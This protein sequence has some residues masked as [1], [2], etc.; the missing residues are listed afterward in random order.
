MACLEMRKDSRWWYGRWATGGKLYVKNLDILIQGQRPESIGKESDRRFE[1]SRYRAQAKLDE[2]VNK[3]NT[4]RHTSEL[5]QTLHEIKT[6]NRIGSI[7]IQALYPAWLSISRHKAASKAHKS[8]AAA[9]FKRFT[10]YLRDHHAAVKE[11]AQVTHEMGVGFMKAETDRKT[12][13]RTSN[14]SLSLLRGS[15]R[16]LRRT[17]GIAD[18]PFDSIETEEENTIHRKPFAPDELT[19]VFDAARADEFC[20]P[21]IITGACTAMRRGDVCLLRWRDVDLAKRFISVKTSKTGAE[22]HIPIFPML[23]EELESRPRTNEYCFPEQAAMYK[24]NPSGI[25]TRL[26]RVFA[27]A[28]FADEGAMRRKQLPLLAEIQQQWTER[29]AQQAR[30]FTTKVQRM[31]PR[32]LALYTGGATINDCMGQLGLSKGAVSTYLKRIENILGYS[33]VRTVREPI[34]LRDAE[35]GER[36]QTLCRVNQRGFHALRA[37]WVTLALSA[38]VPIELVRRV[39]GHAV[40]E[41]VLDHYFEPNSEDFRRELQSRMPMMLTAGGAPSR[42]DQMRAILTKMSATTWARD[43]QKLLQLLDGVQTI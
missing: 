32:V 20:R 36:K 39:T 37:T 6:G 34:V 33:I 31:L 28:G 19:A 7:A 4:V 18:N 43:S 26:N 24:A 2:L 29:F 23:Q 30:E 15:F 12:A 25:N 9:V 14:A 21:L 3:A 16:H 8:W 41:T 1:Q 27:A 38:G 35:R 5:I 22:V 11:M 13:G 17:A 42:D 40:V 10:D